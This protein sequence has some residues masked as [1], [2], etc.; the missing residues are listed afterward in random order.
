MMRGQAER[1]QTRVSAGY[2]LKDG[3]QRNSH[4]SDVEA[5]IIEEVEQ[6]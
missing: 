6:N 1:D 3:E 5:D 2:S 4:I